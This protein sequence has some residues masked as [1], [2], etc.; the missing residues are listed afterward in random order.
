MPG[1]ALHS[2]YT[3]HAQRV[4]S[5]YTAYERCARDAA[6]CRLGNWSRGE[7]QLAEKAPGNRAGAPFC[8]DMLEQPDDV[9]SVLRRTVGKFHCAAFRF[10]IVD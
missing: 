10:V 5:L 3:G 9:V 8:L 2:P 6:F 1:F 7:C 4:H